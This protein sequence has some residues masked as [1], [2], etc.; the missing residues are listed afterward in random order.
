MHPA[1]GEGNNVKG[2]EKSLIK[3][4]LNRLVDKPRLS[5]AVPPATDA[6]SPTIMLLANFSPYSVVLDSTR[7]AGSVR[8][9]RRLRMTLH[10]SRPNEI[11]NRKHECQVRTR[12][13]GASRVK[14]CGTVAGNVRTVVLSRVNNNRGVSI[15]HGNVRSPDRDTETSRSTREIDAIPG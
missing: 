6:E 15:F 13:R 7:I 3:C 8:I 2:V 12:Y 4:P 14:I 9:N 11:L 10:A 5:Y 1:N